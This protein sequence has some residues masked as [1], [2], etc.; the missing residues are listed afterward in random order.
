MRDVKAHEQ[1]FAFLTG[2]YEDAHIQEARDMVTVEILDPA[3]PPEK[4]SRPPR[5]TMILGAFL[6]S[7]AMSVG[8]AALRG[9]ERTTPVMRA[10][11]GD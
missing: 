8:F 3:T 10:V 5:M 2:Q 6:L 7:T 9:E 4:K 11:A 1:V